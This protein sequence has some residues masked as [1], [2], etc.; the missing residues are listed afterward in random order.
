MEF[1]LLGTEPFAVEFANTWYDD[2]ATDYL[3]TPELVRDWFAE[4][5]GLT[6]RTLIQVP[7]RDAERV[8][9]FR[10]HV[11]RVLAARADGTHPGADAVGA[12]ND[13]AAL[14]QSSVR[15]QWPLGD[16]PVQLEQSETGGTTRLLAE[17]AT[18]AIALV[19][20]PAALSRCEGPGCR[21]LFVR[22]HGRRRFCDPTC[23]QRGRQ[24][25]YYR[26]TNQLRSV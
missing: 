20:G 3:A 8:R 6:G 19:T 9:A 14:A 22:H 23:S 4:Y 15:L 18:E 5:C 25:R 1:P 26:R 17:L 10:D 12:V 13:C 21:M 16:S 2:G 7:G 11:H 24:A